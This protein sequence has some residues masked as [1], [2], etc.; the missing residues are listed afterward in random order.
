MFAFI[1]VIAALVL[2][3]NSSPLVGGKSFS[4]D[5]RV[6]QFGVQHVEW[7]FQ[8]W[9]LG[10]ALLPLEIKQLTDVK[11]SLNIYKGSEPSSKVHWFIQNWLTQGGIACCSAGCSS[12][13]C[14][15]I[16]DWKLKCQWQPSRSIGQ[17]ISAAE[18]FK[19]HPNLLCGACQKYFVLFT[20]KLCF[21]PKSIFL[22][23]SKEEF[24]LYALWNT[25]LLIQYETLLTI[26]CRVWSSCTRFQPPEVIEVSSLVFS[27]SSEPRKRWTLCLE[28]GKT[29]HT[30]N[31]R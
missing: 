11:T 2:P 23:R 17:F 6:W 16:L 26:Q 10:R 27:T 22:M 21:I 29:S 19:C 8:V 7:W 9:G 30:R 5:V 13:S 15:T 31:F 20:S 25:Q 28:K 18:T 3:S 1:S 12:L 4:F 24:C 14:R